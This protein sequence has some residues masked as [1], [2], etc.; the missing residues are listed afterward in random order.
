MLLKGIIGQ[1]RSIYLVPLSF[2]FLLFLLIRLQISYFGFFFFYFFIEDFCEKKI[3]VY[4][5]G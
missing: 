2:N 3:R 1:K 4:L 5:V